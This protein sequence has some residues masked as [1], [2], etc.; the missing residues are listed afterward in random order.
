MGLLRTSG[1]C[2]TENLRVESPS[3]CYVW[4]VVKLPWDA[5]RSDTSCSQNSCLGST[6]R[7]ELWWRQHLVSTKLRLP[8]TRSRAREVTL[9]SATPYRL[10]ASYSRVPSKWVAVVG[11]VRNDSG[12]SALPLLT[13]YGGASSLAWAPVDRVPHSR[14]QSVHSSTPAAL[15]SARS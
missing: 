15:L 9:H 7:Q 12:S 1:R 13:A 6:A 11:M 4:P 2:N 14:K 8:V 5:S 3:R 10:W